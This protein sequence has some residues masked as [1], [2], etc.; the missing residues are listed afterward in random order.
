MSKRM[1]A[2][3]VRKAYQFIEPRRSLL[4]SLALRSS[5][6]VYMWVKIGCENTRRS[7]SANH[8]PI[9]MLGA[10]TLLPQRF[11]NVD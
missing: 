9:G 7:L 10:C 4:S 2:G 3:R 1:S 11:E 8:H 6:G 5:I